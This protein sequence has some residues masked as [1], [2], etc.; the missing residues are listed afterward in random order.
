M[1]EYHTRCERSVGGP[2]NPADP[3]QLPLFNRSLSLVLCCTMKRGACLMHQITCR[4]RQRASRYV[5]HEEGEVG[6]LAALSVD[7]EEGEVG[8]RSVS[9]TGLHRPTWPT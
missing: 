6:Q 8:R 3:F 9:L 4:S 7:H 1:P 2:T 5:D